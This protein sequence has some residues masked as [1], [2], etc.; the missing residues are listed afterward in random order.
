MAHAGKCGALWSAAIDATDAADLT[1]A[2]PVPAGVTAERI[3]GAN[4]LHARIA[5][6]RQGIAASA[7]IMGAAA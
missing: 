2:N 4:R 3:G 1:D 5:A 6:R 7:E